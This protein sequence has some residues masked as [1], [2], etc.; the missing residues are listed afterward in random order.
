M[1]QP[2]PEFGEEAREVSSNMNSPR[3]GTDCGDH[4]PIT[5]MKLLRKFSEMK[6]AF[7]VISQTS[8]LPQAKERQKTTRGVFMITFVAIFLVRFHPI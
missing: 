7:A 4:P 3:R 6:L 1:L 2:S 8:Q 5:P